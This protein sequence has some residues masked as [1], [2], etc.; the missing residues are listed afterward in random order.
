MFYRPL[1]LSACSIAPH[2]RW[3]VLAAV[4][5][6]VAGLGCDIALACDLRLVSARAQFAEL[7]IRV[8]LIPDGG[9]TWS[10][11]RIVGLGRAMDLIYSGAAVPADEARAIGLANH[12]FPTDVFAAQVSG[13]AARL[14]SQAP[15]ALTR[16]RQAVLAA[17]EST[18][19]AALAREAE[20]QREIL[21]SADGFEGFR[22][23][24]E[25]RR[26]R[27]QGR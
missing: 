19:A 9:G 8:G 14:A 2:A 20:L 22:A 6:V 1:F 3:P 18:F 23:F 5:G 7:F 21:T 10:L 27:W 15:L 4:D 16:I 25:K 12:V 11:P 24:L 13:Y 17:Q 26:P